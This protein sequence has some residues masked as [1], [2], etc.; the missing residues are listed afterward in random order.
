MTDPIS[1]TRAPSPISYSLALQD[2]PLDAIHA[3]LSRL[4]T[5]EFHLRSTISQ[6]SVP[7]YQTQ[8]WA[9]EAIQENEDV[10]QRY[11]WRREII[12]YE[13]R[14]RGVSGVPVQ[15]L[16]GD[17]MNGH[18][19]QAEERERERDGE[20]EGEG[21]RGEEEERGEGGGEGGA[22]GIEL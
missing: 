13:L 9:I 20:K 14:K 2:L 6:L 19:G 3:E 7:E 16:N 4:A 21:H 18:N 17:L 5:S 22:A 1:I 15:R 11:T 12:G 10:L 8:N